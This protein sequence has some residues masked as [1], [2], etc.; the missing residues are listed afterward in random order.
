MNQATRQKKYIHTNIHTQH[1]RFIPEAEIAG[2][3][4]AFQ[5]FLRDA[6]DLSELV[7]YEEYHR[8]GRW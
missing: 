5:I 2:V 3:V 1:S 7:G 4:E 8:R 6:P